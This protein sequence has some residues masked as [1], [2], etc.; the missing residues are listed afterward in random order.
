[1]QDDEERFDK[2]YLKERSEGEV[3]QPEQENT[4]SNHSC[5]NLSTHQVDDTENNSTSNST[6]F[7]KTQE[8]EN[9]LGKLEISEKEFDTEDKT[10]T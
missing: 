9:G 8:L 4:I 6:L 7:K 5:E 3:D 1:M 2:S 10:N